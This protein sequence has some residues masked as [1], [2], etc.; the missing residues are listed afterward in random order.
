M[1]AI[2]STM[3]GSASIGVAAASKLRPPWLETTMASTPQSRAIRASSGCRMPL[4]I[5]GPRQ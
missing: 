2:S 1:S 5:S 4:A 3:R